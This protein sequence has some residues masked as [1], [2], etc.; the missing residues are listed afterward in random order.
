MEQ[1]TLIE[2]ESIA[3]CN[4]AKE[5]VLSDESLRQLRYEQL[6]KAEILGNNYKRKVRITFKT[7]ENET[8]NIETTIWAVGKDYIELKAGIMIPIRAIL[9]IRFD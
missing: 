4:F 6:E 9:D 1:I 8:L 7:E 3:E 5:D 2:K